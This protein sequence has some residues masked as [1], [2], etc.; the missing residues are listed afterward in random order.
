M[1]AAVLG[2]RPGLPAHGVAG[3]GREV[4]GV[5]PAD[6]VHVALD[7]D[8]GEDLCF[9]AGALDSGAFVCEAWWC[10]FHIMPNDIVRVLTCASG[11]S[12][13]GR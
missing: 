4:L 3:N 8:E 2:I 11:Q 1:Q 5:E 12:L 9:G 6:G 7:A 13:F 10:Y